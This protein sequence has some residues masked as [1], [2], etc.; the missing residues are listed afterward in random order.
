MRKPVLLLFIFTLMCSSG[1]ASAG[2]YF[3]DRGNDFLDCF[4]L[5]VGIGLLADAEMRA[6]DLFSAGVGVA[7]GTRWGIDG[8]HIVGFGECMGL[9]MHVGLPFAPFCFWIFPQPQESND[10]DEDGDG[11][12]RYFYTDYNIREGGREFIIVPPERWSRRTS[13]S[14]LLLDMTVFERFREPE[15]R[16]VHE[17]GLQWFSVKREHKLVDAFDIE[18]GATLGL[19]AR[20]GFSLGQFLDFV[21]G[22]FGLDLAKDDTS[23][24]DI[25]EKY[26]LRGRTGEIVFQKGHYERD[27]N[28]YKCSLEQYYRRTT[29][30][31]IIIAW[32]SSAGETRHIVEFTIRRENDRFH[33][34][35]FKYEVRGSHVSWEHVP[36][37]FKL[38]C[39]LEDGI[40]KG[41]ITGRKGNSGPAD[42]SSSGEPQ[43]H[44]IP[45][46]LEFRLPEKKSE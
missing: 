11:V 36:K 24:L 29:G 35:A 23:G 1:C 17:E 37:E 9:D 25:F 2:A 4:K 5:Q 27:D 31:C 6:T 18:V 16:Q 39:I 10:E 44:S 34:G 22:W 42:T 3:R 43:D 8:R 33:I 7:A 40:L 26:S 32:G 20:V 30:S 12:A 14:I 28:T 41:K 21:T 46:E 19:S 45:F 38:D 13:K 15:E